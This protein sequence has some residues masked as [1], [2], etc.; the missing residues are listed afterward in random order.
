MKME[1]IEISIFTSWE[2][3]EAV[4]NILHDVGVTGV[5]I[6]DPQL[7]KT[8][9]KQCD[10]DEVFELEI[11]EDSNEVTVRGYLPA[12][13][14]LTQRIERVREGVANLPTFGLDIGR[15]EIKLNKVA[16]EDWAT[17]WKAYFKPEHIGK[18]LVVKPTWEEYTAQK[19]EI[20]IHLDPGMAFGTGTHPTTSMCLKM[21]EKYIQGKEL[22]YDVGTG[23][24]ILSV[25]AA[26]LG[27]EKIQ[28]WDVDLV[29]VKVAKDN[30][31]LNQLENKINVELGSLP[32][33]TEPANLIVANIVANIILQLV[34]QFKQ[35]LLSKGIL[36]CSGIIQPREEEVVTRLR[37]EGLELKERTQEGDWVCL[38]WE[39][40]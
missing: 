37:E 6:E 18:R 39:K 3:T 1:W 21:L 22:V 13:E 38:V 27:A 9:Q 36:I 24:G 8:R 5:V 35:N 15:G 19:E 28:A 29:A 32:E 16:E 20:I 12:D 23:S 34:P 10:F 4:A 26:R 11:I 33:K 2:A 30:V 25:A 40:K 14:L 17:S 7:W 31:K